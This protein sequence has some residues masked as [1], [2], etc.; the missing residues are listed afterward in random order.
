MGHAILAVSR[1]QASAQA[2]F[3]VAALSARP[4]M[5]PWLLQ[6]ECYSIPAIPVTSWL[7]TCLPS[8]ALPRQQRADVG[9]FCRHPWPLSCLQAR[10]FSGAAA[11]RV[12]DAVLERC[13]AG[14]A[15]G[16]RAGGQGG[17]GQVGGWAGETC[18]AGWKKGETQ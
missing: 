3:R 8:R 11:P 15:A 18:I 2:C 7:H 9:I 4:G 16:H 13:P 6:Q 12:P 5:H 17:G 1:I 14:A 10:L